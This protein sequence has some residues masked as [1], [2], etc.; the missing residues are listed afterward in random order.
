[1]ADL[2]TVS[3]E[4]GA[5]SALGERSVRS[6]RSHRLLAGLGW[7]AALIVAAR[8]GGVGL[9]V[10]G[11]GVAVTTSWQ[12]ALAWEQAGRRGF[13]AAA[14]L[15][16]GAIALAAGWSS[17]ALGFCLIGAAALAVLVA[18]LA[19]GR[20]V[21]LWDDA[22]RLLGTGGL[23]GLAAG[24]LALAHRYESVGAVVVLA[25]AL[26]ADLGEYLVG[27]GSTN[28]LEGPAAAALSVAAA[29]FA[30]GVFGVAPFTLATAEL[31]G[32]VLV[33]AAVAGPYLAATLRPRT[34]RPPLLA[35]LDR[36]LV[37][38]PLGAWLVGLVAASR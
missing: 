36:L 26:A 6:R 35:L 8:F 18:G 24:S 3:D 30:V 33:V 38:G 5:L 34:A 28:E 19:P 13:P 20:P 25:Y 32:A 4:T 15:L 31:V 7:A 1:M 12:T 11:V 2:R 27:T 21:R 9:T 22:G 14:A 23:V 16:A 17:V 37:L 29:A 10:W